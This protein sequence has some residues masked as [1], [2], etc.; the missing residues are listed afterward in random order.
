MPQEAPP[1]HPQITEAELEI[2]QGSRV[3]AM[4]MQVLQWKLD[5][6]RDDAGTGKLV[7]SSNADMTH[8]MAHQNM[9]QQDAL[10][11]ALDP[12][13]MMEADGMILHPEPEPEEEAN[14]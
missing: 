7:D 5:K 9:G 6:I 13:K 2:W 4:F 3:T 11:W 1:K 12:E 8:A 10:K 14:A